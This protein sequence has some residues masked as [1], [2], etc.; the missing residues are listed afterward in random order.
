VRRANATEPMQGGS[1]ASCPAE[2]IGEFYPLPFPMVDL[3][4]VLLGMLQ[5]SSTHGTTPQDVY[6]VYGRSVVRKSV[7]SQ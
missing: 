3:K 2:V 6:Y 5:G 4:R 1:Q 7:H